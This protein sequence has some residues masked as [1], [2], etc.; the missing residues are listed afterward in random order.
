MFPSMWSLT[1]DYLRLLFLSDVSFI[2]SGIMPAKKR[3][4]SSA[5]A[6][7]RSGRAKKQQIKKA[8]VAKETKRK[9]KQQEDGEST[10]S[11]DNL[12]FNQNGNEEVLLAASSENTVWFNPL[13]ARV[14]NVYMFQGTPE[15][16]SEKIARLQ[17]ELQKA[18]QSKRILYNALVRERSLN[19]D[20]P[21][22][23]HTASKTGHNFCKA[24]SALS[25]DQKKERI[26]LLAS[27]VSEFAGRYLA[28]FFLYT[29]IAFRSKGELS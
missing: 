22:V 24:Y 12:E 20:K 21:S 19:N 7:R 15:N 13:P 28:A 16:E 6:H 10:E 9:V 26:R 11:I 29:T 5:A 14:R 3:N 1:V 17:Q 18:E 27:V 23:A 2:H 8:P 25:V 4:N